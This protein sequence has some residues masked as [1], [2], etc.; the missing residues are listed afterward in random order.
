MTPRLKEIYNKE[1][2]PTLKDT[3]GLKNIF[4]TPRIEKVVLNMGL[5]LDGNDSKIFI[6]LQELRKLF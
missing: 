4:M 5:G 6:W 3:L 1:I 2:Q